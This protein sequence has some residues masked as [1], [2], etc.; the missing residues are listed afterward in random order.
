MKARRW[1]I[2]AFGIQIALALA[3]WTGW[4]HH[5]SYADTECDTADVVEVGEPQGFRLIQQSDMVKAKWSHPA[6]G[7]PQSYQV[8]W[9][10]QGFGDIPYQQDHSVAGSLKRA[11][12][13]FDRSTYTAGHTASGNPLTIPLE[14]GRSYDFQLRAV[15]SDGSTG[16]WVGASITL[17]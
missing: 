3:L 12:Y 4:A 6:E 16:D 8:Q 17:E 15:G 2:G 7:Q 11:N 9:R 1:I 13:Y 10:P 5:I 14:V